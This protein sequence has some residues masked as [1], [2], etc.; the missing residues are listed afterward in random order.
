MDP[1]T[2]SLLASVGFAAAEYAL[3]YYEFSQHQSEA[4]VKDSL[5]QLVKTTATDLRSAID[6]ASG[7]VIDKLEADKMEELCARINNLSMLLAMG[8]KTEVLHY[9]MT[10]NES[11][12][13]ANSRILERKV[14]WI[15]PWLAGQA[16]F[17]AALNSSAD[18]SE[19]ARKELEDAISRAKH[20]VLSTIVPEIVGNG[21]E[22]PWPAVVAFLGPAG[23]KHL[24][25]IASLGRKGPAE[26]DPPPFGGHF[27][28]NYLP[29]GVPEQCPFCFVGL[30][31]QVGVG[32]GRYVCKKCGF[33]MQEAHPSHRV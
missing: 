12:Q 22:I 11:V 18:Q 14:Q 15:G 21:G 23:G 13:Y 16:V 7:R 25:E 32:K 4:R 17:F 1:G 3:D 31:G 26:S 27:A 9:A 24:P 28:P 5:T 29:R 2:L 8:R 6:A 30:R 19:G 33:K 10:L 20:L